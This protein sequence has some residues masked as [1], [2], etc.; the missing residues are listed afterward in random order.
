MAEQLKNMFLTP[1]S[2]DLMGDTIAKYYPEFNKKNFLELVQDDQ[3]DSLEL[4][5]KMHH[6]ARCLHQTLPDSY[7]EA[8]DILMKAAPYVKGFEAMVLP[9]FVEIYG[10]GDWDLSL[11]AL[12]HF[13][14]FSSS[15][16]AIRP[17]LDQDP[18]RTMEFMHQWAGHEEEMVRRLASEGSRPRLPWAMALPKFKKDPSP[19]IPILE[20]L[21]DDPS[22]TVRRSVANNLNDISKDN[23]DI[24]LD[25]CEKWFG[26]SKNTD[27]LVKHALRS[28]LKAGNKRALILFGFCDPSQVKIENLEITEKSKPVRIGD[29]VYF[30]FDMLVNTEKESKLRLE[31]AVYYMKANGKLSKKVFQVIEKVYA[32]GQY[33]FKRKQSF[34]NMTTRKHHPGEHQLAII[35][36]GEEKAKISFMLEKK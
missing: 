10:M 13:T 3:W 32:P 9:D 29:D 27:A 11:P 28:L 31:Y 16:F 25:T 35:V 20:K 26:K 21:K 1:E 34:K 2:L 4:K 12:G 7:P 14:R 22:E 17:F 19:I 15:E 18:E 30:T 8:L 5:D 33:S 36:N 23:P 24:A 6:T